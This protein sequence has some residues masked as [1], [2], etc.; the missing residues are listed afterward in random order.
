MVA[1]DMFEEQ[2]SNIKEKLTI[3]KGEKTI[4]SMKTNHALMS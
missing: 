2:L 1:M 3:E 4:T